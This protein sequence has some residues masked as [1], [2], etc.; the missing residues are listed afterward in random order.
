M[1]PGISDELAVAWLRH[2]LSL[3][4]RHAPGRL[5]GVSGGPWS[6]G[7]DGGLAE[8]LW[9]EPDV[10]VLLPHETDVR[11]ALRRQTTANHF[12]HYSQQ[13]IAKPRLVNEMSF[14]P[15]AGGSTY[16]DE[17]KHFWVALTSGGHA[18]RPSG[19]PFTVTP[20]WE[21]CRA[22]S[23]FL[24]GGGSGG[25]IGWSEMEPCDGVFTAGSGLVY[26]IGNPARGE[27]LA[28]FPERPANGSV[29]FHPPTPEER[30][31]APPVSG[32]GGADRCFWF[33][34]VDPVECVV[35]G[36]PIAAAPGARVSLPEPG[37]LG[38]RDDIALWVRPCPPPPCPAR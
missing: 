13:R 16:E 14:D 35:W 19:Q 31:A 25:G 26:A 15:G 7:A 18:A 24:H 32:G 9:Q 38:R 5:L 8:E 34:W 37:E 12:R 10:D 28:Y 20:T 27:Y 6:A 22:L 36:D 2:H 23:R 17:R 4:R 3:A 29:T 21:F 1:S 33:T 11:T 30:P